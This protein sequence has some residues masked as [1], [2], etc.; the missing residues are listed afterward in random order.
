LITLAY[1][2]LELLIIK[3]QNMHIAGKVASK[4]HAWHI[5]CSVIKRNMKK[6]KRALIALGIAALP[7]AYW[8]VKGV[9][10]ANRILLE[11]PDRFSTSGQTMDQ[12]VARFTAG[13]I[14]L[15]MPL[16]VVTFVV[17]TIIAGNKKIRKKTEPTDVAAA[18]RGR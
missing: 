12:F 7:I 10:L 13:G 2:H 8:H 9:I 18:S 16:F 1:F 15:A 5:K 14:M 11:N 4:R 17:L 6:G 3:N